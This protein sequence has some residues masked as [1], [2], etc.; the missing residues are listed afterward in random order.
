MKKRAIR[1]VTGIGGVFFRS[2][3]PKKLCAWYRQHLGLDI[4]EQW[5][6]TTFS[7]REDEK[8]RR[9]GA[10]VWSAFPEKTGYLGA[11][12]QKFMINYRVDDLE[13]VLKALKKEGVW[14]DPR[15]ADSDFGRFAWIKDHEGNRI[16]LWQPPKT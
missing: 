11:R 12:R 4:D 16:E 13:A 5:C 14:I 2:K 9:K 8:P 10:T 3:D 1:R 15:R 7:W 6:G